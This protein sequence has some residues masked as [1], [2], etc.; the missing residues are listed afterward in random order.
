[1][2]FRADIEVLVRYVILDSTDVSCT[3]IVTDTLRFDKF[4]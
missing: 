4:G 1:M 2:I 3:K